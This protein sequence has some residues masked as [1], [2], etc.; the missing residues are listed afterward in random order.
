MEKRLVSWTSI[1]R[2]QVMGIITTTRL[3]AEVSK[4][5]ISDLTLTFSTKV[6]LKR[7]QGIF[8]AMCRCSPGSKDMCWRYTC[9]TLGHGVWSRLCVCN[10][11]GQGRLEVGEEGGGREGSK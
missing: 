1:G 7:D 4:L 8:T 9:V 2:Q 11:R 3:S 5:D 10:A 6:T